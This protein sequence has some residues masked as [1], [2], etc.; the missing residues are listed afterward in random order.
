MSLDRFADPGA[1]RAVDQASQVLE[2][3]IEQWGP[4]IECLLPVSGTPAAVEHG[5]GR[6][7][8]GA[9]VLLALGGNVRAASI[10][11]WTTDTAFLV[12]DA[13]N[14]RARIIF[15]KVRKEFINA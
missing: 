12:A 15:V 11:S 4:P 13:N 1:A 9:V 2:S 8:D 14:T 6:I 7:P 5:L 3:A 10:T